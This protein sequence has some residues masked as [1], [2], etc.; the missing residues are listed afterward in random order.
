MGGYAYYVWG[1]YLV[2][3]LFMVAELLLVMR[4]RRRLWERLL[5]MRRVMATTHDR[6]DDETPA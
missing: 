3:L 5:R 6:I 2:T 1:S 4:R